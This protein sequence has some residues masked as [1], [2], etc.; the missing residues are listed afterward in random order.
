MATTTWAA[1][2][3]VR[4]NAVITASGLD[5]LSGVYFVPDRALWSVLDPQALHENEWNRYAHVVFRF[6]AA[7][8]E[9]APPR[10]R[11]VQADAIVIDIGLCRPELRQ[12]GLRYVV[13]MGVLEASCVERRA[14]IGPGDLHVVRLRSAS[15]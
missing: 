6:G 8:A 7:D 3:D 13:S 15:T 11:A 10:F 4:F 12:L 5:S 14:A 9:M 2:E 1:H